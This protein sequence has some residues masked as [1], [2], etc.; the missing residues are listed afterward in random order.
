VRSSMTSYLRSTTNSIVADAN[1]TCASSLRGPM[2]KR[3]P[4]HGKPRH[5]LQ[6][7]LRNRRRKGPGG[8]GIPSHLGS[9]CK[10]GVVDPARREASSIQHDTCVTIISLSCPWRRA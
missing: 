1:R 6:V 3:W 10:S 2:W 7:S 9:F 8:R 4:G 5:P